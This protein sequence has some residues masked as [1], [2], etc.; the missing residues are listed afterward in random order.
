M[1]RLSREDDSKLD[2]LVYRL[3]LLRPPRDGHIAT[4]MVNHGCKST[5]PFFGRGSS[6]L[7]IVARTFYGSD[8]T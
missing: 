8:E 3:T 7:R 6:D 4:L 1:Q 2:L 5:A